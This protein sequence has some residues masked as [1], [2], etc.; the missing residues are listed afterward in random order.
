MMRKLQKH[1]N[2]RALVIEKPVMEVLGIDENTELEVRVDGSNLVVSPLRKGLGREQL[3]AS[4]RKMR[5]R[6]DGM[7]QRLADE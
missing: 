7:L 4:F 2:S 6:Y 5:Q 3:D 1:G